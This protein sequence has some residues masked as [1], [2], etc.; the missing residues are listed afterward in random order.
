MAPLVMIMINAAVS[1]LHI[2]A[3]SR[4][5]QLVESNLTKSEVVVEVQ[6]LFSSSNLFA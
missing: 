6:S 2:Q 4:C 1:E 5:D 3:V